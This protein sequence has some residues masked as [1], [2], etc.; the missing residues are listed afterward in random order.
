MK[1]TAVAL[2]ILVAH[3][4]VN[5]SPLGLVLSGGGAKGAYD[6][7][8]LQALHEVGL[9]DGNGI[10]AGLAATNAVVQSQ[11]SDVNKCETGN[12]LA[13]DTSGIGKG[14][15]EPLKRKRYSSQS[16]QSIKR[17]SE[18]FW[19]ILSTACLVFCVGWLGTIAFRLFEYANRQSGVRTIMYKVLSVF[20]ACLSVLL[21]GYCLYLW[22]ADPPRSRTD[23][24]L[25]VTCVLIVYLLSKFPVIRDV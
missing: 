21:L 1:K 6:V 12:N 8:V 7:G 13:T 17:L 22:L 5:A 4:M 15:E 19:E 16:L 2:F 24:L 10:K 9:A 3:S 11:T 20:L 18:R 14:K 25:C 23:S